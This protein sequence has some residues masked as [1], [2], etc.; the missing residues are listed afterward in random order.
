MSY[1]LICLNIWNGGKLWEPLVAFLRQEQPDILAVQ[2]VFLNP[3]PDA[4]KQ[5]RTVESL[6][7]EIHLPYASF[8]PA[9]LNIHA[10]REM[11]KGNA[12]LS[13]F[14]VTAGPTLFYDE[15]YGPT[16]DSGEVGQDYSHIPRNLQHVKILLP[17][18]DS[19]ARQV[20]VFNTQGIWGTDGKDT[21]RRLSM[22]EKILTAVQGCTPAIVCGD[23]NVDQKSETM[24]RLSESLHN[25]F[26]EERTTSFQLEY[27]S[28]PG[29]TT[30]VV[31]FLFTTPDIRVVASSSPQA[32][33]SDHLPL[34]MSFEV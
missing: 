1:N 2:E 33:I 10:G 13:K 9:F 3:S 18:D 27:K 25:V 22:G 24:R 11:E 31:D 17:G 7:A 16:D 8:A 29:Y 21:P 5:E 14:P 23:F 6:Q 19:A 34:V 26:G 15:P 4:P 30:A 20:F 28:D 12:V 32:M